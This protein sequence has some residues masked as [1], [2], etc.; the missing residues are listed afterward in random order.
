MTKIEKIW[1]SFQITSIV[2]IGCIMLG[3]LTAAFIK[4]IMSTI[5]GNISWLSLIGT[6]ILLALT[7]F[8]FTYAFFNDEENENKDEEEINNIR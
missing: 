1:A 6:I 4:F 3:C 2:V 7:V 8:T 5:N